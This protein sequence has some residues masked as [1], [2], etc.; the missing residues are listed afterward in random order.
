MQISAFC[1]FWKGYVFSKD[2]FEKGTNT[3]WKRSQGARKTVVI[4]L[5]PLIICRSLF[6][7]LPHNARRRHIVKLGRAK[8]EKEG[9]HG[10]GCDTH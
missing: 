4:S 1:T 6:F 3:R 8:V 2:A 7:S 5:P 9:G 10:L